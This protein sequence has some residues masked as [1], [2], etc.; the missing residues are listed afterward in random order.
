MCRS[1]LCVGGFTFIE[2]MVVIGIVGIL[3]AIAY[4]QLQKWVPNY[5]LK[6]AAQELYANFQKAKLHAVKTNNDV[7]LTYSIPAWSYSFADD[8]GV[9]VVSK[10]LTSSVCIAPASTFVSG[11]SGVNPRGLPT[12]TMGEMT[13]IHPKVSRQYQIIQTIAGSIRI[14]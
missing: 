2:I 13:L 3:S 9:V 12:G 14:E 5:R 7:T 6:A 10:V 11:T 8:D 4:P 1:R